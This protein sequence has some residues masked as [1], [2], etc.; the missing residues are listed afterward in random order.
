MKLATLKRGTAR[1]AAVVDDT[2]ALFWPLADLFPEFRQHPA[3]DM[4]AAI[5]RLH[6]RQLADPPKDKGYALQEA[7]L[8]APIQRP[9]RNVFCVGKNYRAHAREFAASG[10]D[11]S[12]KGAGPADPEKP[13]IFTKPW[14]AIAGPT[15]AIP[16]WPNIDQAVDYE[17]ELAVVIGK[18]GRGI[19]KTAA[20][21][22]VFGYTILNDVT[23]RDLQRD[24]NQWYLGKAVDGFAPM[25]PWIVTADELAGMDLQV[26]TTVNGETRQ[27]A[28]TS[29]LI[30]DVPTLIATI[31]KGMELLPGDIIA[32]GT[33]E[34]VGIGFNPPRF[35]KD[36]DVVEV[37]ISHVGR[38]RNVVRRVAASAARQTATG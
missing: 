2:Q 11:A 9:P 34:G 13:I 22:H 19:S 32:T 14:T 27:D 15:D 1:M 18:K 23:A 17:G 5:A 4:V 36:G 12:K 33:P 37:E 3:D 24:H 38:I 21:Q 10:F 30:F 8:L 7:L 16:L 35:L 31:S 26:R 6:Q 20:L 25:G 29:D 28:N